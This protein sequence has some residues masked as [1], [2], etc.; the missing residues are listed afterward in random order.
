MS[1][2]TKLDFSS[3]RQVK[4]YEKLFTAL[5]GGT[6]FGMPYSALTTGP[7][8]TTTG[9]TQ[10]YTN[11]VS[12]FSGNSG[13]TIFTWY[14][15]NMALGAPY[16]SAITPSTSATTQEVG[17][18]FTGATTGVT[19]DGY[20]Y[21]ATYTGITFDLV[22]LAMI[23]LGGGA[24]SGSVHT[25]TLTYY[26]A[27]T[28]DYTGRTIWVDVS[29]I[30]RT[31]DLI[32]TKSPQIGYVLTCV[33]SEGRVAFGPVSGAS[34]G[35][36]T[37]GTLSNSIVPINNSA[38]NNKLGVNINPQTAFDVV[39]TNGL[40]RA[41]ISESSPANSF[42]AS[43]NTSG[44][45]QIGAAN[46]SSLSGSFGVLIGCIGINQ[47]SYPT[48]GTSGS[49]FLYSGEESI[50]LNIIKNYSSTFINND[51]YIRFYAGGNPSTITN[52]HIHIQGSGAT[53][54][55]VGFNTLIPTERLDI[56]GN[57]RFRSIGSSASAGALHYTSNGTLTTNT[58]DER[59]K[60]N[61]LPLSNALNTVK[62]LNGVTYQWKD[63]DSG[64]DSVRI[65]FIA[66]QVNSVEPKLTFTNQVDGYMG[67]H[68]N[69]I[70]PIL[71]EAIKELSSG[72]TLSANT[73]LETQSIV[74][75]D[76]NIDLNFGGN[77]QTA[78][79]GGIRVLHALGVDKS[80]EFLIDS[81]GNWK[82]NTGFVPSSIT[83][84]FYTPS[85][86]NDIN[87]SLGNI[88]RD[89]DYFYIKTKNGWKRS[90]LESF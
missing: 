14:D 70:I 1:F 75:E 43:G 52:A 59:L 89:D 51:N 34:T 10:T 81:D 44:F 23:D 65:G 17:P 54:G 66:Q 53:Q 36:W 38:G 2:R 7:D 78:I 63:K 48:Y 26:S 4:Q 56:N 42:I 24:Y 80:A 47:N 30:T 5:S 39:S 45:T 3:N 37:A 20:T 19:Q 27:S 35:Y 69:D 85:D 28:L 31:E 15:P 41:Y 60:E 74:A 55:Y 11:L 49:T 57:A 32:M 61:I 12:T 33:D 25:N 68:T 64:G 72:T 77:Q 79:E 71:V 84:P 29:G 18:I 46:K 86:S 6:Q 87:G 9:V 58:S 82:T 67:I 76:N 8:L 50:G 16:L 40:M 13:T 62:A 21:N 83:I 88:T 90:N 73:F 22:G